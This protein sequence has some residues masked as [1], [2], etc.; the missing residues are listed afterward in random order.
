MNINLWYLLL[1]G[2]LD[3]TEIYSRYS[4]DLVDASIW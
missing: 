2:L 1:N 4:D 3:V